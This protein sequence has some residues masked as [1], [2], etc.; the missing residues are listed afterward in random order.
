MAQRSSMS[1]EDWT[2]L[3]KLRQQAQEQGKVGE[4]L[5]TIG[6]EETTANW[7]DEEIEARV[8]QQ[9]V[10]RPK[11]RRSRLQ[12]AARPQRCLDMSW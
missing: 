4:A 9:P 8:H 1:K 7:L 6:V 3:H 10:I 12:Q 11:L 2:N 5:Q